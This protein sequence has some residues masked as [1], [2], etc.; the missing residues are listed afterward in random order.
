MTLKWRKK[1]KSFSSLPNTLKILGP[2]SKLLDPSFCHPPLSVNT[3]TIFSFSG[4]YQTKLQS[5][6]QNCYPQLSSL[7]VFSKIDSF[8]WLYKYKTEP[9]TALKSRGQVYHQ[10]WA[11]LEQ[12]S[13]PGSTHR[14][15]GHHGVPGNPS[16]R[17]SILMQT[18]RRVKLERACH[19]S[20]NQEVFPCLC[21]CLHSLLPCLT[22][23]TLS[24]VSCVSVPRKLCF[25]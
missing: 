22:Q 16:P 7:P 11:L 25:P 6:L 24:S 10:L 9:T 8:C 1:V 3:G 21:F 14:S 13:W 4:E 2:G 20:R 12:T 23:T 5:R 15:S 19:F 17:T 18:F